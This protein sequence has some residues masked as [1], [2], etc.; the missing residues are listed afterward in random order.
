[1]KN[2]PSPGRKSVGPRLFR[3]LQVRNDR[4]LKVARLLETRRQAPQHPPRVRQ[5]RVR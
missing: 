4:R 5:R 2:D 1:M 3:D